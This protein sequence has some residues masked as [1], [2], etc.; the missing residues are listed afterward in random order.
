MLV[1]TDADMTDSSLL[2]A[3]PTHHLCAPQAVALEQ[4]RPGGQR[5]A[6][7][8]VVVQ[9]HA[10]QRGHAAPAWG[11]RALRSTVHKI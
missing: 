7:Q 6:E 4:P 11:H 9:V 2:A 1:A 10:G 8:R 5:P 3:R